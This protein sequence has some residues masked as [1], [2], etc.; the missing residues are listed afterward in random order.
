MRNQPVFDAALFE[1]VI[2]VIQILVYELAKIISGMVFNQPITQIPEPAHFPNEASQIRSPYP[3]NDVGRSDRPR[4]LYKQ[5]VIELTQVATFG[6]LTV[7]WV[8]GDEVAE[9]AP[10]DTYEG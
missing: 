1:I 8:G 10:I 5:G 9:L 6:S 4:Q 2:N 3:F 7:D